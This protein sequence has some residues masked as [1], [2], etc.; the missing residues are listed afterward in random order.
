MTNQSMNHFGTRR[1]ARSE[2]VAFRLALSSEHGMIRFNARTRSAVGFRAS[3][4]TSL[5]I[6]SIVASLPDGGLCQTHHDRR[7]FFQLRE[8]DGI[9]FSRVLKKDRY[10]ESISAHFLT[11]P[12]YRRFPGDDEFEREVQ[13]RDL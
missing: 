3:S 1:Q 5:L 12:S 2:L 11:L 7:L 8:L 13:V 9:A 10:L 4:A 6:A